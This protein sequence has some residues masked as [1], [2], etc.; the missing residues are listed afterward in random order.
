MRFKALIV[1]PALFFIQMSCSTAGGPNSTVSGEF[2]V[3]P[4]TLTSLGFDWG[5]SGDDNRNAR[6][7]VSYRKKGEQEWRDA[8]PLFRLHHE[9]VGTPIDPDNPASEET[10]YVSPFHYVVPNM[11]SGSIMDLEPDTE[12]ECRFVLS[13]PDGVK[14]P[15]VKNVVARTRREPQPAEGGR[16]YHVY[17]YGYQ[18]ERQTPA[19]TGLLAAYYMGSDHSD[20][21]NSY[22]LRVQPGDVIMV[23]AGVYKDNRFHYSGFYPGEA[24]YPHCYV[25]II[26]AVAVFPGISPKGRN[27]RFPCSRRV[28]HGS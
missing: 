15:K 3:E 14:G 19:F 26:Q 18:G 7:E 9:I 27:L 5:I 13:D 24:A 17:P 12:Y 22:A 1:I 10:G 4:P 2:W 6:V 25:E 28:Q 8:L 21:S 20:H 16:V 11:F 23:H